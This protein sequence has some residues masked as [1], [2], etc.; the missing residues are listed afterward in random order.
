MLFVDIDGYIIRKV[1]DRPLLIANTPT[2]SEI[3][4]IEKYNT[5]TAYVYAY[6]IKTNRYASKNYPVKNHMDWQI[7]CVD[8][9][10]GWYLGNSYLQGMS[11]FPL[12]IR[13]TINNMLSQVLDIALDIKRDITEDID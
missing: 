8:F 12:S 9:N 5:E 11:N 4:S 10:G 3:I 7:Y 6:N 13:E 1:V 2:M